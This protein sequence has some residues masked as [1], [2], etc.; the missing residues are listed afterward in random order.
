MEIKSSNQRAAIRGE[1][2][3]KKRRE[4]CKS[5]ECLSCKSHSYIIYPYVDISQDRSGVD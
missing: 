1:E 4:D 2:K 3:E 5:Q